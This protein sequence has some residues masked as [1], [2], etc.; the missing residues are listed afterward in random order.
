M[1]L[2]MQA[3]DD[4]NLLVWTEGGVARLIGPG[5]MGGLHN[6]QG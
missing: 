2:S 6:G 1:P 3:C 5:A 4:T